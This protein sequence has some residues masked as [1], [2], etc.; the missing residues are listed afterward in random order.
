MASPVEKLRHCFPYLFADGL[1]VP[2]EILNV[3]LI[4][5]ECCTERQLRGCP[6]SPFSA[7][8]KHSV[9][10]HAVWNGGQVPSRV[11]VQAVLDPGLFWK[12]FHIGKDTDIG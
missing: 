5:N 2:A 7:Q 11:R 12:P 9:G 8:R 1:L 6:R 3:P 10:G 4:K